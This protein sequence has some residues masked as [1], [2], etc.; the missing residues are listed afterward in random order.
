MTWMMDYLQSLTETRRLWI[1]MTPSQ[2]LPL[3]NRSLQKYVPIVRTQ[4]VMI[5]DKGACVSAVEFLTD[6]GADILEAGIEISHSLSFR[7]AQRRLA[8]L[9]E[10]NFQVKLKD[11]EPGAR[12]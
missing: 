6:G 9:V 2:I 7:K 1:I 11:L 3:S 10:N 5:N 4:E 8:Q 12:Y